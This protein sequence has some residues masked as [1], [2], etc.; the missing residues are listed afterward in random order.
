V[1]RYALFD[2]IF[3]FFVFKD[4]NDKILSKDID[5]INLD[6]DFD[7]SLCSWN[8][9]PLRATDDWVFN[10][11]SLNGFTETQQ[12]VDRFDKTFKTGPQN[13]GDVESKDGTYIYLNSL[14]KVTKNSNAILISPQIRVSEPFLFCLQ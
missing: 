2:L 5:N 3:L 6:C 14:R 4:N 8:Q 12:F 9:D 11:L 10:K 7:N 1:V 13:G